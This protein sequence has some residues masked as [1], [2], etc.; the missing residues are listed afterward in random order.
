MAPGYLFFLIVLATIIIC[1]SA[2]DEQR[3]DLTAD[4]RGIEYLSSYDIERTI[5]ESNKI[6]SSIVFLKEPSTREELLLI[7]EVAISSV[8]KRLADISSDSQGSS[9]ELVE[10]RDLAVL[11]SDMSY[12]L[13]IERI[14]IALARPQSQKKLTPIG[15]LTEE[16]AMING[17][18]IWENLFQPLQP[19]FTVFEIS[20]GRRQS[21]TGGDVIWV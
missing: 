9:M 10:A 17:T 15:N 1:P 13:G 4:D 6:I 11:Y 14:P 3:G 19:E 16:R 12:S 7:G 21:S 18:T 20:E 5:N 8:M 2:A